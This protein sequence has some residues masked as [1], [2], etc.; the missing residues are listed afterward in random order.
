MDLLFFA[1]DPQ[2][3]G[4]MLRV[5]LVFLILGSAARAYV[6]TSALLLQF[7]QLWQQRRCSELLA[8]LDP[9]FE[10]HW[11]GE[12]LSYA[13]FTQPSIC[14]PLNPFL[15]VPLLDSS[16]P[17]DMGEWGQVVLMGADL[18]PN[19]WPNSS[20]P[21]AA[22]Y[23]VTSS[24]VQ[25][26]GKLL[27]I[28]QTFNTSDYEAFAGACHGR[29]PPVPQ[30]QQ[31]LRECNTPLL[32][33]FRTHVHSARPTGMRAFDLLFWTGQCEQLSPF[34]TE[35]FQWAD[36][37]HTAPMSRQQYINQCNITR[38]MQ[39]EFIFH[40]VVFVDDSVPSKGAVVMISGAASFITVDPTTKLPC[41]VPFKQSLM[42]FFAPG[43]V[44]RIRFMQFTYQTS[45]LEYIRTNC[46]SKRQLSFEE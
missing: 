35:D 28:Y 20:G 37:M 3:F 26:S 16:P 38:T 15:S 23:L 14:G 21:C 1:F 29:S 4:Q 25:R 2:C 22:P 33:P 40:E 8:M 7:E 34:L 12:T 9:H 13:N 42:V 44:R 32:V 10:L 11:P 27:N 6:P 41:F 36:G 39:P 31:P 17:V 18:M 30:A 43:V 45:A 24:G 19:P 46:H 5:V